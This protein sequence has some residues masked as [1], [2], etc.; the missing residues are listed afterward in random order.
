MTDF[1]FRREVLAG[2]FAIFRAWEKGLAGADLAR[3]VRV[4]ALMA[5]RAIEKRYPELVPG[6]RSNPRVYPEYAL[7]DLSLP[8]TVDAM[9]ET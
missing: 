3:E 9:R 4:G 2:L 5:V 1:N 8:Q 6:T 7:H